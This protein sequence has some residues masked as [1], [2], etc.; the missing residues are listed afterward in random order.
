MYRA[1]L[2]IWRGN[3]RRGKRLVS[4]LFV[5]Y[6]PFIKATALLVRSVSLW[7]DALSHSR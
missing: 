3:R 6:T 7:S 2:H 4:V 1:L 5:S